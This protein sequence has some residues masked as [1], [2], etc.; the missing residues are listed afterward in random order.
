VSLEGLPERQSRFRDRR[1]LDAWST[2]LRFFSLLPA[3]VATVLEPVNLSSDE[4]IVL[5]CLAQAGASLSMGEIQRSTLLQAGRV[6]RVVDRLETRRLVAWRRPRADRRKVLVRMQGAARQLLD[7]L[8]PVMF[9]LIHRA[10][11][12]LGDAG[13]EFMRAKMRKMVSSVGED[14][15]RASGDYRYND[16]GGQTRAQDLASESL[17][18]A[19]QRPPTWGLAGWL[20][21]CQWSS[22]VDRM[23]RREFRDLGLAVPQLQVLAALEGAPEGATREALAS[24]TGLPQERLTSTLSALERAGLVTRSGNKALAR[25]RSAKLTARGEQ[26]VLQAFPMANRLSEELYRGLNDEDLEHLLSLL[27]G[28]CTAARRVGQHYGARRKPARRLTSAA[29]PAGL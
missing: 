3:A 6:R 28:L 23:W 9:D 19:A 8:T 20:R 25:A 17:A 14:P 10:T 7:S 1:G 11:E 22:H 26:K 27:S 5:I 29:P 15:T 12:P 18:R 24:A 13:T 2:L 4:L 16:S 21:F